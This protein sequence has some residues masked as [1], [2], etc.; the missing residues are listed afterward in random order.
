MLKELSLEGFKSWE[1]IKSMRLAPITGLFGSNSSGKTSILQFL[2][3]LKQTSESRD[4]SQVISFGDEQSLVSLGNFRN[5]I[6]HMNKTTVL[7]WELRWSLPRRIIIRD[8]LKDRES[9][10]L[11]EGNEIAIEG[12]IASTVGNKLRVNYMKYKLG[13][14]EFGM[15]HNKNTENEYKLIC[16]SKGFKFLRHP[17][18]AWSLPAPVKFYGFPFEVRARYQN[19]YFLWQLEYSFE[20]MIDSIYYLRPLREQ[21]KPQYPWAGGKPA[22]VGKRGE[23]VIDA[24]LAAG[25]KK[26]SRGKGRK[27]FTL[28]EYVAYWLK[29]MGLINEFHVKPIT[30]DSNLYEVWCQK[31]EKAPSVRITDVGFG[32]SQVL[33]V[34]VLCYYVPKGSTVLL[35]QPEIHLHPSAQSGLADVFIDAVKTRNIQVIVESHSEHLLKRLQRRIAEE[36]LSKDDTALYFCNIDGGVSNLTNLELD[37]FGNIVNWPKDFFGDSFGEIAAT[38]EA[39]MNRKR[40]QQG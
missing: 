16:K 18:R 35:E 8:R 21:P 22:D 1:R 31:T 32:V 37:I 12:E 13:T 3:M 5:M 38:T 34:L 29:K 2:L 6:H 40:E 27:R 17:G 20:R 19:A 33:P 10:L 11:Y 28:E 4:L 23:V 9:N 26:I 15:Q 14:S 24:L 36:R 30:K 39:I 25:R 7:H